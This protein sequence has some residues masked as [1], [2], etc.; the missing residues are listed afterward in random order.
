MITRSF[1]SE[2]TTLRHIV[3]DVSSFELFDFICDSQK[4]QFRG[5]D[6]IDATPS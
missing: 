3:T 2:E 6:C 4:F 5:N 1:S